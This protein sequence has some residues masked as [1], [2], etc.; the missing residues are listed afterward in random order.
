MRR[1]RRGGTGRARELSHSPVASHIDVKPGARVTIGRNV[2]IAGGFGL[3]SYGEIVIEDD[4]VIGPFVQVLDS[5][6]HQAGAHRDRPAP[7][8]VR[9]GRAA[10]I[11]AWSTILPGTQLGANVRVRP[12]SVVSGV[13]P[14]DSVI[15]GN[16]A[17]GASSRAGGLDGRPVAALVGEVMAVTFALGAPP[18]PS[19]TRDGVEGWNSLG[20]LRLLDALSRAV[21]VALP[22]DELLAARSVADVAAAVERGL[23]R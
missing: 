22:A 9:L 12:Y 5:D 15:A 11:G 6:L 10:H 19:A 2:T 14:R 21:G 16:P 18:A 4:V 1:I 23:E 13:V 17:V 8:P 7:Q 20:S 3:A